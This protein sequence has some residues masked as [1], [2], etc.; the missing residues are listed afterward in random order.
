M[1]ETSFSA[2]HKHQ[3]PGY[4]LTWQFALQSASI[5]KSQELIVESSPIGS[6]S[7][8]SIKSD[9]SNN[10]FEEYLAAP[11]S[12]MSTTQSRDAATQVKNTEN[13]TET[14]TTD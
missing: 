8:I 6:T 3:F 9:S 4:F 14:P 10:L 12:E 13:N 5:V 2:V 1:T 11:T 7:R